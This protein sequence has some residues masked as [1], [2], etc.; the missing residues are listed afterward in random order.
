MAAPPR[1]PT[2]LTSL[3]GL[4]GVAGVA[5]VAASGNVSGLSN[6][7]SPRTIMCAVAEQMR[8]MMRD[9]R[10][11]AGSSNLAS[12]ASEGAPIPMEQ[13]GEAEPDAKRVRGESS[14]SY[15]PTAEDYERWLSSVIEKTGASHGVALVALVYVRRLVAT[16]GVRL[17][18]ENWRPILAIAL[19]LAVKVSDD[20]GISNRTFAAAANYTLDQVNLWER[21]FCVG[22]DYALTVSVE[23]FANV[24]IDSLRY[25]REIAMAA[26]AAANARR[27]TLSPRTAST[28]RRA[29]SDS[30]PDVMQ[31]EQRDDHAFRFSSGQ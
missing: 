8:A 29:V 14:A 17:T 22:V 2:L 27:S 31:A 16:S 3:P 10:E 4:A 26:A 19:L 20:V 28:L 7:E 1:P 25:K 24:W 9:P 12:A 23:E 30:L 13:Q 5:G 6:P 15:V 21:R 11:R 18:P